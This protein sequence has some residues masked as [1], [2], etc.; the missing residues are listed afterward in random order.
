MEEPTDDT[1]SVYVR[2]TWLRT[3]TVPGV[4]PGNNFFEN[5][6]DDHP[7]GTPDY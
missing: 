7:A 4:N 6:L 2:S 5:A 1:C 3:A